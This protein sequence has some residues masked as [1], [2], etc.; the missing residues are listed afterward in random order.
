MSLPAANIF[1]QYSRPCGCSCWLFLGPLPW[2]Y[3]L[4]L[5]ELEGLVEEMSALP[6]VRTG[7]SIRAD[8]YARG[9]ATHEPR[10]GDQAAAGRPRDL[11]QTLSR[12]IYDAALTNWGGYSESV[13]E[14]ILSGIFI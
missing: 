13:T 8:R 14:S 12:G 5:I 7:A 4:G 1:Q 10:P 2:A 6:N 3:R 9:G 11:R